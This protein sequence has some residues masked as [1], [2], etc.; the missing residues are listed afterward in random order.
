MIGRTVGLSGASV[1]GPRAS[2]AGLLYIT[3]VTFVVTSSRNET[4]R[5]F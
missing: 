1:K 5:P 3:F 4:I 2:H